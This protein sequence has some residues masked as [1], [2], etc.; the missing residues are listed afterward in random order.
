MAYVKA[1]TFF[2]DPGSG[3]RTVVIASPAETGD[4]YRIRL[5]LPGGGK[6]PERHRHPG[7]TEAFE[8][9]S[10]EVSFRLGREVT[11]LGPGEGRAV[12][13][14]TWT[15][16]AWAMKGEDYLV[17]SAKVRAGGSVTLDLTKR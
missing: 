5:V 2:E 9:R 10:G 13:P 7:L 6:G 4:R 16:V 11:T 14:G 1:G 3:E 17:T 8:V 15:A 12:P